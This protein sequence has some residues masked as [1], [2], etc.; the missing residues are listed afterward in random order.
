MAA[1]IEAGVELYEIK[2]TTGAQ[3]TRRF[4]EPAGSSIGGLHAK[5]FAFDRRIGFIGSY[6]LDPRSKTLNPEI[7]AVIADNVGDN[8]GDVAGMGADLFESYVGS[9]VAAIAIGSTLPNPVTMMLLPIVI[10]MAGLVCSVVGVL[11]MTSEY[12]TGSIRPHMEIIGAD[13]GHVGQRSEEP[14]PQQRNGGII[15]QRHRA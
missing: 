2:P 9:I 12:T 7:A 15:E 5:T 6:N 13:G 14:L 11:T 3:P 1:L 8:V 10:V 4:R